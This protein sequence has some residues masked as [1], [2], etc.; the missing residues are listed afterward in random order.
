M[1][2]DQVRQH[3]RLQI[4]CAQKK[5]PLLGPSQNFYSYLLKIGVRLRTKLFLLVISHGG[6]D[7]FVV[8]G[9]FGDDLGR[10]FIRWRSVL[11]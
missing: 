11:D 1:K 5:A 3:H 4:R 8:R 2:R 10:D 9:D 6:G 7:C